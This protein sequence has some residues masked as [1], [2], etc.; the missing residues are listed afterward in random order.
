MCHAQLPSELLRSRSDRSGHIVAEGRP[1]HLEL[2]VKQLMQSQASAQFENDKNLKATLPLPPESSCEPADATEGPLS[3]QN[4]TTRY[5]GSTHRSAILDDIHELRTVLGSSVDVLDAEDYM[6]Y[7]DLRPDSEPIFVISQYLPPR[8]EVDRF[9]ATYFRGETFIIPFVHTY[10]FQHQYHEFWAEPTKVNPLWLSQLFCICY[11]ASHIGQATAAAQCLVAG[12]YHRPQQ[13]A[14]EALGM[15]AQ[16]KNLKSLDPSREAGAILDIAVR[17]AY[18]MGYHRDPDV[19]GSLSVFEGEMRRRFWAAC[20]QM[21]LM[22]SFQLGLPSNICFENCDT[23]APRNLFDSDFNEDTQV[24]PASRPESE[25]TPLLWFIIK[26]RQ[27]IN[28][29]KMCEADVVQLDWEIR[30]MHAMI[31]NVLRTRPLSESIA[32]APFITVTRIFVDFVYLKSLCVL[33]RRYMARGNVFSTESCV[34]AA[35]KVVSQFIDMYL[36]FSP[37]G[38]LYF[39][40]W[41]LTNFTMN[42][43]LLGVMVLWLV[44]HI[45]WKNSTRDSAIDNT[46][47]IEV[48]T[49]LE[50]SRD[51]RRISHA[52]RLT[53]DADRPTHA[54]VNTTEPQASTV[55]L[56]TPTNI[57]PA[58]GKTLGIDTASPSLQSRH[59]QTQGDEAA[60]E[61]LDPF[62]FL[63][64]D[65]LNAEWPEIDPEIFSEGV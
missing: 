59:D 21:N 22:I 55:P 52:I 38:Q 62:N 39:E 30:Q 43:F 16:C 20:K 5:L 46:I 13:F 54:L 50:R 10:H 35:K 32:D 33:H 28:F 7:E 4:E 56:M 17:L 48:R 6:P 24:L 31:P 18:E 36:E 14:P 9:V 1:M 11:M 19:L 63:S 26:D 2:A 41:M 42:D 15:Y 65:I 12:R 49:L 64:N 27:M 25:A 37:G 57:Q 47:E 51:A 8:V 23:K 34:E 53:L 61:L 3:E 44:L 60:F 40:H 29:S 58:L 45:R